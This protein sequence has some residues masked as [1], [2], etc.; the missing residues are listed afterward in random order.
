MKCFNLAF[1]SATNTYVSRRTVPI[2]VAFLN[3]HIFIEVSAFQSLHSLF[4][5]PFF[6]LNK[7]SS[8]IGSLKSNSLCHQTPENWRT[9]QTGQERGS[10]LSHIS[11]PQQGFGTK[12][13]SACRHL[14]ELPVLQG[15]LEF[16][17]DTLILQINLGPLYSHKS[18]QKL[19]L[20]STDNLTEEWLLFP[21]FYSILGIYICTSVKLGQNIQFEVQEIYTV[22][23]NA[24]CKEKF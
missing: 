3:R 24:I 17:F 2:S 23:K 22:P 4:F 14:Q 18:K 6:P 12:L 10:W 21:D 11:V 20:F 1:L 15:L 19:T 7:I 5:F 16:C 9:L 8:V 13:S